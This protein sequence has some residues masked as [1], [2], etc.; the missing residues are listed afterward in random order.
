MDKPARVAAIIVHFG[1]PAPTRRCLDSLGGLD[2]IILV[3]QP[4]T[5]LGDDARITKRI[6]PD[7][8]VGFAAACNLA[9]AATD[10]PFVLLVN[11]DA[12]LA[13]GS[14]DALRTAATSL[15]DDEAGACLKLL[16][17]DGRT[18]QSA[19]GLYF[20]RD[21]IGF[22][23][24]FGQTDRGQYD[25]LVPDRIGVPSGAAA[26]FRNQAWRD[27]GGMDE[28]FFCYCEDG[29][30]GLRMVAA[31]QRFAWWPQVVVHHELS[32]A[33]GA[34]SLFKAFHVERN[35]YATMVHTGT[36]GAL[37]ML[38][39]FTVARFLRVAVD[40][41]RGQGA[42]AGLQEDAS[43]LELIGTALRAWASALTMLPRAWHQRRGLLIRHPSGP[44]RVA[45]FLAT[46]RVALAQFSRPRSGPAK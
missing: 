4:P 18:I 35:H 1:D 32:R 6:A 21:G 22:P 29:D 43:T 3:D 26:L 24:G 28:A 30:L 46:R 23:N 19:G 11:N 9:V 38:P 27:A 42:S 8:N 31:G 17:L 5:R 14:A 20:T 12:L 10:A 25:V 39:F 37:A 36:M 2:E 33:T 13:P 40:T 44:S 16:D 15:A 7:T 34:H 45:H 41:L